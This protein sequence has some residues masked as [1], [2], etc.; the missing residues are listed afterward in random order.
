MNLFFVLSGYL[1][2][3]ILI[4]ARNEAPRANRS[5]L[6]HFYARRFL[7][8]FPIYY[9]TLVVLVILNISPYR[10]AWGWHALYLQNFY[11]EIHNRDMW[12]WFFYSSPIPGYRVF[13][14]LGL[15]QELHAAFPVQLV[16]NIAITFGLA[17]LSWH[18]LESPINR[19]KKRFPY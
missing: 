19:L 10:E 7:R 12:L 9:P 16:V 1:I 11:Q 15:P 8:L 5:V 4:D 2:S 17:I 14:R 6:G 3:G 18:F 13:E